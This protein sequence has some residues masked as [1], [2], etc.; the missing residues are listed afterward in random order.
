MLGCLT[1]A[2]MSFVWGDKLPVE[3]HLCRQHSSTRED[4][5]RFS[6]VHCVAV[7]TNGDRCAPSAV[8]T[9]PAYP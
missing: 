3:V 1:E 7:D 6:N 2:C 8:P 5:V 4:T 9:C